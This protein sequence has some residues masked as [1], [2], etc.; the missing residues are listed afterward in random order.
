MNLS[1]RHVLAGSS[2]LLAAS[3][4]APARAASKLTVAYA[5]SMGV[6]I[7]HGLAPAFKK[8]SHTEIHGI[9][10]G[11][12]ALAHLL[13]AKTLS[14]DV[15]ISVSADPIK[16]VEAAGL[17]DHATPIASTAMVLAYAPKS[18]LAPKF[19]AASEGEWTKLITTPGLRFGRTDPKV[20]PQGQY[21]L[22][23][24]QLAEKYYHLPGF[25][26]AVAGP[27]ENPKQ[28]FAE[29]SLLARLQD[30][31]ID[32]TL[33]YQSGV[34]SQH[35]PFLAL[36]PQ[37]DFGNPAYAKDWYDQAS[38]TLEEKG[39]EKTLHPK[40]LVFYAAALKTAANPQAAQA[41]VEFLSSKQ[42]QAIFTRYGYNPGKGPAV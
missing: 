18:K 37:I 3:G 32:A 2:T 23:T 17:I 5:G 15:F 8:H 21:V 22:F 16:I 36:P 1:R 38:L 19:A 20:D 7:D 41:F 24:L 34:V 25:A 33:G 6:V 29:P 10:E 9:G 42:A 31:Q 26:Q 12:M 14:A 27:V 30:G 35:L 11:A 40:P 39:T 13:A 4:F 28:V